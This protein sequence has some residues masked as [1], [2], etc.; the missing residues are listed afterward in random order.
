AGADP[1]RD[2]ISLR[3]LDWRGHLQACP[4]SAHRFHRA[5]LA[6]LDRPRARADRALRGLE[7]PGLEEYPRD[8]S[9]ASL[10]PAVESRC[11]GLMRT[12][13]YASPDWARADQRN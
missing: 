7:K 8:G 5:I 4:G 13:N 10:Q 9:Y 6:I 11:G 3:R 1:R 2:R 12:A